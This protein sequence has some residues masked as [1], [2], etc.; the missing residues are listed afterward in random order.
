V[1]EEFSVVSFQYGA[2]ERTALNCE[3]RIATVNPPFPPTDDG[4]LITDN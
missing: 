3:L 2:D 4:K 1:R